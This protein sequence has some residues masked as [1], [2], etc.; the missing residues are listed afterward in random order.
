MTSEVLEL[1]MH[2]DATL[3]EAALKQY[4][5]EDPDIQ[6]LLNAEQYSLFAGGKRIRPLLTLGFCRFKVEIFIISALFFNRA[7]HL[8]L[9][10]NNL[11]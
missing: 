9:V 2:K 5:S 8:A 7:E 4:Y 6:N 10:G 11:S 3:T 1:L